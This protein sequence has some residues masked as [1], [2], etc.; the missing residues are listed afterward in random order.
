M[1]RFNELRRIEKAIEH[2][3]PSELRWAEWYCRMRIQV[4]VRKDHVRHWRELGGKVETALRELDANTTTEGSEKPR[5]WEHWSHFTQET[6]SMKKSRKRSES[7][8]CIA[9]GKNPC[10]CP[11]R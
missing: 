2:K 5:K 4:A 10:E 11:Q 3:D 6:P 8:L 7:G 1:T 9:C